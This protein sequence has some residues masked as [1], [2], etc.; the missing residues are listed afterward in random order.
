MNKKSITY[1]PDPDWAKNHR[2]TDINAIVE[3]WMLIPPEGPALIAVVKIDDDRN[4]RKGFRKI[5][6]DILFV[7]ERDSSFI[8]LHESEYVKA[9]GYIHA[10][11]EKRRKI[12]HDLK[13]DMIHHDIEDFE[14]KPQ[15][16]ISLQ[17]LVKAL[18][19]HDVVYPEVFDEPVVADGAFSNA[20]DVP[21]TSKEKDE[22]EE[23]KKTILS[24]AASIGK[25]IDPS[26]MS[27]PGSQEG[28][29]YEPTHLMKV[30]CWAYEKMQNPSF[31]EMDKDDQVD[32]LKGEFNLKRP[33]ALAVRLIVKPPASCP[34]RSDELMKIVF[35][36]HQKRR[37]QEET[38][39]AS[40]EDVR[41]MIR[42]DNPSI[43]GNMVDSI[44]NVISTPEEKR[45]GVRPLRR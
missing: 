1:K 24:Y 28:I 29:E 6:G 16:L 2:I 20:L 44:C 21:L 38:K 34:K 40:Q 12:I 42:I 36:V 35:D 25:D 9:E 39:H 43:S 15:C 45:G 4:K 33:D 11:E 23:L 14:E 32:H 5:I 19:K 17:L 22:L 37:L 13:V 41:E 30:M 7:A 3:Q 10:R 27:A 8:L 26:S 18:K 31:R